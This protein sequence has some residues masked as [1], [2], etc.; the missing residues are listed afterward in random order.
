MFVVP[1]AISGTCLAW[2]LNERPHYQ[3]PPYLRE[4]KKKICSQNKIDFRFCPQK[5]V[6]LKG[7]LL[8]F[9]NESKVYEKHILPLHSHFD[10]EEL[11]PMIRK[12]GKDDRGVDNVSFSIGWCRVNL[13]TREDQIVTTPRHSKITQQDA[14][15]LKLITEVFNKV[16]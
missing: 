8:H 12:R 4:S 7:D 3:Y 2:K 6:I 15:Y 1:C 13:G 16:H 9:T 14:K 10:L 11:T 5:S